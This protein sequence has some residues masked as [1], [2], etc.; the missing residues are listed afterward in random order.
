MEDK[1]K[2]NLFSYKWEKKVQYLH[3][4]LVK[5]DV[6]NGSSE[7]LSSSS[8]SHMNILKYLLNKN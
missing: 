6:E 8:A 2:K 4:D 5:F 1:I 3:T 7:S